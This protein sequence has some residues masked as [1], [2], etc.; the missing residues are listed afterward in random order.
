MPPSSN[1]S[2]VPAVYSAVPVLL[3]L[4]KAS[5]P[6]LFPADRG[7]VATKWCRDGPDAAGPGSELCHHRPADARPAVPGRRP[8]TDDRAAR[9]WLWRTGESHGLYGGDPRGAA[10]GVYVCVRG[11]HASLHMSPNKQTPPNVSGS[12]ISGLGRQWFIKLVACT[13]SPK[14]QFFWAGGLFFQLS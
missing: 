9:C 3:P 7:H 2:C 5:L 12:S 1:V 4:P 8:T 6:P 14:T 11:V 13:S 10:L